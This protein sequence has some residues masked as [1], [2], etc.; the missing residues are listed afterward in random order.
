MAL[1]SKRERWSSRGVFL[2]AAI[3]S[4][5]GLGNVW[6]FPYIAEQNGG[7]A[8]LIPYFV[9]LLTAGIPLM[10]IEFGLGQKFQ[11][12][13]PQAL[14]KVRKSLEWVGWLGIMVASVIVTYYMVVMAW[15]LKYLYH[16]FTIPWAGQE[17][18]FFLKNVLE[19]T[20]DPG[21]L[22][23]LVWPLVLCLAICWIAVFLILYKGV[24]RVGKVV[25]WTVP[26]PLFLLLILLVRGLTLDGAWAGVEHYLTADFSVLKNPSVWLAAYGQIFF[27]LSV[28]AGILIAY[29]SYLPKKADINNNAV[30]TS[31]ANCGISFFAGF[32]VFSILGY[33]AFL[34]NISVSEIA[35]GGPGLAF[36]V[37]PM[38]LAKLPYAPVFAVI[39]FLSLLTL[40]I[41]SAFSITEG[42]IAAIQDRFKK[43]SKA[44]ITAGVSILFF[45]IGLLFVTH[46][47]LIWLDIV[48]H[49]MNNYGLVVVGL[50]E[51]LAIG[52]F[53]N[54]EEFKDYVNKV[55]DVKVGGWWT[56][57]VKYI[58]PAIL[59][60]S[61]VQTTIT[62]YATPYEGYPIWAL[63]AG[64]WGLTVLLY[65]LAILLMKD[66]CKVKVLLKLLAIVLVGV[67][68]ATGH[69]AWA[70]FVFGC[71]V[72]YGGLMYFIWRTGEVES[73]LKFKK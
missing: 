44:K 46:P 61:L 19:M 72:L 48:D 20:A 43:L 11:A 3:G 59:I 27:S 58:T 31:L 64:G 18:D 68:I 26:L 39:F 52:Y 45:L 5:V 8:F 55:S 37:F 10:I 63:N 73:F 49:W 38:A 1:L 41:D 29:A 51:C 25:K 13:A 12:A 22:G 69:S 14:A 67:L 62:A 40:G 65:V 50:L 33:F 2:F 34:Q 32:A 56:A 15:S 16:A 66:K 36:V 53:Y 35:A 70:M 4:A 23:G 71:I 47:G 57:C 30:I 9:A 28:G 60:Y 21:K 54:T 42:I 24:D 17:G 7:G 6:R